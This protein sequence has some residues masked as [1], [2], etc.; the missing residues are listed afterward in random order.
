MKRK[1]IYLL[2][3]LLIFG[4]FSCQKDELLIEPE[5]LDATSS[6]YEPEG[7]MVL[8]DKLENPYS[9]ENMKKAYE[10]LKSN[11][12][13]KSAASDPFEVVANTLYIRFLP[14]DSADLN[15]LWADT[16]IELFDYP[17]VYEIVEAGFYYHD[18]EI[19]EGQPTWQYTSVPISYQFPD[20]PYEIIE[21]CY[22]P[23]SDDDDDDD[24]LK[25][26]YNDDF[27]GQLEL[28][29]FR[30][31]G[32]LSDESILKS[33]NG[34]TAKKRKP[35]GIIRVDNN[36]TKKG[37][38]NKVGLE[39]VMKVK[40]RVHNFVKWN[41]EYTG[42]DGKYRMSKN[43]RTKVHYAVVY[44]N[45]TG[46]KIWGNWAMLSPAVY[47][48]GWHSN[49]GY[50]RDIYTN[51]KA[52]L[53]STVNNGAYHYREKL[54]PKYGVSKPTSSLRIWTLRTGGQ[55]G[56]SAPMARQITLGINNLMDF[57]AI[58]YA[59]IKSKGITVALSLCLPD[60]FLFQ[61]YTSTQSCYATLWHELAHASHYS[62]VGKVYWL[63][64]ISA[65]TTNRGYGDGSRS[66]DGYI[67]VGEMWGNYFGNYV[68]CRDYFGEDV[69]NV[70]WDPGE[71][72][73]NPGF[74][75]HS[76]SLTGDLTT[77]KIFSCLKSSVT[78]IEKLKT[79][80]KKHTSNGSKIDEAY[81]KFKDWPK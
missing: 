23:E 25:S 58:G 35:E 80:L 77:G 31:T 6:D 13:L 15:I 18:P 74:L 72:W 51:S 17:M 63:A 59:A 4:S 44:E 32:N 41:S 75:M 19:P 5:N 62:K 69:K 14:K 36:A 30:I 66:I 50:S 64:Y 67:G 73:Y 53:W 26:T 61:D 65:I 47:D 45:A 38:S 43:F 70:G 34:I 54:C 21:E 42:E 55:W 81:D 20:V 2:A 68:C 3:L 46:F 49:S 60:V 28:E 56:G 9:V 40:V 71:D 11:G 24:E 12:M 57:L 39:G 7:M 78:N 16:T 8:G 10:S 76:V 33:T 48:M 52:W 29:A 37:S 22:I 27:Y 79:E 1:I